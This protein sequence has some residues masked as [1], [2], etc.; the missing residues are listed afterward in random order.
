LWVTWYDGDDVQAP[1]VMPIHDLPGSPDPEFVD[2]LPRVVGEVL[3]DSGGWVSL[4]PG[5]ARARPDL[6]RRPS[7]G[8]APQG[9]DVT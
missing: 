5:P 9:C 3:G 2:N 4:A 6:A 1:V 7:V 8:G